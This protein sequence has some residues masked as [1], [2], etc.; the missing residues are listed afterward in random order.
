MS[1]SSLINIAGTGLCSSLGGYHDACAAFRAGLTRFSAHENMTVMF[2]GDEEP[3]PLTVAPAATNLM[4]YQGVGRIIKLL[5]SAHS[6]LISNL[7]HPVPKEGLVILM[8]IPDPQ[9]RVYEM[10]LD[11]EVARDVRLQAYTDLIVMP[12]FA[13]IDP[14][15]N[16]IPMQMVFGERIAF[17]RILKKATDFL[18]NGTA[19]HCL[20]LV[21]DS[22]TGDKV[23]DELLGENQLKTADNPVGFI[24]GEGA[25]MMLLSA[26]GS[27]NTRVN[28]SLAIDNTPFDD[29]RQH[30]DNTTADESALPDDDLEA[31]QKLKAEERA[32]WQ[33][34]KLFTMIR[35]LLLSKYENQYLPQFF[36]DMNGQ[37]NRAIEYGLIQVGFQQFYPQAHSLEEKI[38]ALGFAEVGAMMGPLAMA[39]ILASVQ[40]GYARHREF[41]ISLSEDN[42]KRAVIKLQF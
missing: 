39:T 24:P 3:T 13:K 8:A 28:I 19:Q 11:Q 16:D 29:T 41:I 30:T 6:D 23:L 25:A 37:E 38:T 36:S 32:Q 14:E 35:S 5:A 22:L 21:A 9:T 15:L 33:D 4:G 17:A 26:S 7:K 34:N 1:D 27:Q 31:E 10:E 18:V 42:G 12:L 2:S 20:L 40:R